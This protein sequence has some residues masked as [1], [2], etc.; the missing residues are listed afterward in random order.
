MNKNLTTL[1]NKI[2]TTPEQCS[3]LP[4]V[5]IEDSLLASTQLLWACG[6]WLYMSTCLS[7]RIPRGG[8]LFF[9]MFLRLRSQRLALPQAAEG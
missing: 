1:K 3:S 6:G 4:N 8:L 7:H 5:N 2:P 9:W